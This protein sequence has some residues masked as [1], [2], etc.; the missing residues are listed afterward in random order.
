[1]PEHT[2]ARLSSK[3]EGTEGT[4]GTVLNSCEAERFPEENPPGNSGNLLQA[5]APLNNAPEEPLEP[6]IIRPGFQIHDDWFR[7][8]G[9]KHRPGLYWHSWTKP[10]GDAEPE[11]VDEWV[12][13]P[14]RA[15]AIT[16]NERGESFGLLLRFMNPNGQWREWAAPMHLLKGSAEEL[17]GELLNMGVRIDPKKRNLLAQWMMACYPKSRIIAALRTGWHGESF[18][19]PERTIGAENIRFQSEHAAHNDFVAAG[20][21]DEWQQNVAQ[22]CRGN[23]LLLLAVS[24]AFAGPLLKRAKQQETGGAGV[25]MVGDSSQGKTTALQAAGSVWGTPGFVRTWRATSNGLEATAAALNDTLLVLDEISECDPREIGMIVYALANGV[26]KQR[27]CRTGSARE[28]ARW[29]VM[30]LS[31]GERSLS[32]HMAEG[33]KR[34]K[35]G[36][37]ARLLDVPATART[38]GLFDALHEYPDGRSFADALKQATGNH[39]GQAGPA[40][41]E[42]VVRDERDLPELYAKACKIPGFTGRDGVEGRAASVFAL[43]GL[44]GELATEYKITGWDEGEAINAALLGFEL[45]REF[46]GQGQTETRQILQAVSD[47]ILRNG[48]ARFSSIEDK[49]PVRDRA[50][51][52]KDTPK[53]H[54]YLF[55]PPGLREAAAGF[56]IRRTLDA[57]ETAG[58]IVEHE[59][60]KRSK[61]V[62]VAGSSVSLYAIRPVEESES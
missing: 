12:C 16:A 52:W 29:R 1:M 61:K 51:Y 25:H 58:W 55:N 7:L 36:Q 4:Q 13:T 47:F 35:A 45:W 5:D 62:K 27:A 2:R 32:A 57:L 31:S 39:C 23:P 6:E 9:R 54:I 50:G 15:D 28:S 53:G 41:V 24:A 18:V 14:I 19:L 40:F 11:P 3:P 44:A 46:R 37:E 22:L 34:A 56:D 17:R 30:A 8:H 20:T 42:A 33:G 49:A 43:L 21:L 60:G 48:D 26:G 38:H 10:K 59:N